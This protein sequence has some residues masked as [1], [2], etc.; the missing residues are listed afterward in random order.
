MSHYYQNWFTWL[1][2]NWCL[3]VWVAWPHDHKVC[4][5][6]NQ[7]LAPLIRLYLS[8]IFSSCWFR[9]NSLVSNFFFSLNL[10]HI[11]KIIISFCYCSKYISNIKNK[12]KEK[13]E[14]QKKKLFK[15]MFIGFCRIK[16]SKRKLDQINSELAQIWYSNYWGPNRTTYQI[17]GQLDIVCLGFKIRV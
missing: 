10:R 11:K 9:K 1:F 13:R 12:K 8:E 15:K 17:W 7:S 3:C 4:I 2:R 6:W 16:L 14:M 5:I